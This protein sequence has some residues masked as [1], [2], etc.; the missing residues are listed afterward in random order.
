MTEVR[1]PRLWGPTGG[2]WSLAG[3]VFLRVSFPG[4]AVL[5]LVWGED[6]SD[7]EDPWL[8]GH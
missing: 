1:V 3:T 6:W 8:L 2:G 5:P 7:E 4:I